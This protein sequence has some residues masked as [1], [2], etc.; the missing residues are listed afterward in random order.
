VEITRTRYKE[1]PRTTGLLF[2]A[3]L[4]RQ[5]TTPIFFKYVYKLHIQVKRKPKRKVI[6]KGTLRT[7][8]QHMLLNIYFT[9]K[10][11]GSD[12]L[13]QRR[14]LIVTVGLE[15]FTSLA[16]HYFLNLQATNCPGTSPG[17][18]YFTL[19]LLICYWDLST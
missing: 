9:E 3:I 19:L 16:F 18:F 14:Q 1:L 6:L 7:P 10:Q 2:P 4:Q 12:A 11:R 15:N 8:E 13:C 17:V 5:D